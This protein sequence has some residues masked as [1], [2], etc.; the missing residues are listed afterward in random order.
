MFR[1]HIL[2]T[3]SFAA[4]RQSTS[5]FRWGTSLMALIRDLIIYASSRRLNNS[6]DRVIALEDVHVQAAIAPVYG[7][8]P[9]LDLRHRGWKHHIRRI[10]LAQGECAVVEHLT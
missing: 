2:H 4:W 3:S 9:Y 8:C 1:L 5:K 10:G 7:C 6:G